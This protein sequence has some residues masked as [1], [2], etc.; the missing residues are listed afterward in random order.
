[1]DELQWKVS[2]Y[3]D[4]VRSNFIQN[5]K[6]LDDKWNLFQINSLNAKEKKKSIDEEKNILL[7][8]QGLLERERVHCKEMKQKSQKIVLSSILQQKKQV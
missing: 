2:N 8:D 7:K 6:S 5:K 3:V 4:M 1:M